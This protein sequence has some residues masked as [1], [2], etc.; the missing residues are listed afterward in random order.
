M[1][2]SR[3]RG[4]LCPK[5]RAGR[6]VETN[7]VAASSCQDVLAMPLLT[8]LPFIQSTKGC[9]PPA[10]RWLSDPC[11]LTLQAS[12]AP[13][14]VIYAQQIEQAVHRILHDLVDGGGPVVEARHW[15]HDDGA[16]V[17]DRQQVLQM[18]A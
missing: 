12:P 2:R 16:G 7:T 9:G 6:S 15:R 11:N 10:Q 18:D 3:A 1:P 13:A 8:F 4:L 14:A 5:A 17:V